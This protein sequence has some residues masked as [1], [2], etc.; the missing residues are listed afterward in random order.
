ME[1]WHL[2]CAW[3]KARSLFTIPSNKLQVVLNEIHPIPQVQNRSNNPFQVSV[4]LL[5]VVASITKGGTWMH[6]LTLRYEYSVLK[7]QG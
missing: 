7:M 1:V 2:K 4:W 5:K 3:S 6:R